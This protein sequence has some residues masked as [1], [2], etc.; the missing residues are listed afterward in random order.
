M[1]Y[2]LV[3]LVTEWVIITVIVSMLYVDQKRWPM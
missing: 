2:M 3:T 1:A